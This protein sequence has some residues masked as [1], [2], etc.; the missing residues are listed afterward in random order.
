MRRAEAPGDQ[1][2]IGVE[3]LPEG[4]FEILGAVAD[5]CDPLGVE[6]EPHGFGSEE[7]PIAVV[8]FA[9]DEL[10]ARHDDGR[11]RAR[12]EV[13]RAM[14]CGVTTKVVPTGRSTRLP[15]RRTATF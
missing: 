10:A 9:P 1:A 13:A 14:R 7:W 3:T 5:D 6:S 4:L 11:T 2:E 12:Q 8:A 15:L